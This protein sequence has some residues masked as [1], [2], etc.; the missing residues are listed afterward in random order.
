MKTVKIDIEKLGAIKDSSIELGPLMIFSGES[1]LG[2]S[3][4]SF[5]THYLYILLT[6]D[7]LSGFFNDKEFD[8]DK[9][10][11]G[12]KD[13]G[14]VL[15]I[16]TQE[17]LEWINKDAISYIGYLLGYASFEGR[18][19]IQLP[20]DNASL[21]YKFE[22]EIMGLNNSE[23]VFYKIMLKTFVYR[24]PSTQGH[25]GTGPFVTLL[26]AVLSDSIFSDYR[27]VKRTY[28]MPTS[29]GSLVELNSRPSF[30]S[31]MYEEYF[32]NK[33]ELERPLKESNV[34]I[35][36]DLLECLSEINVGDI[37]RIEGQMIYFTNGVQMPVT[38]AASSIKE[39]APLTM[40]FK[41]YSAKGSSILFEEP[42]A[43]LHPDRQ[44]RVADLVGCAIG[45]GCHMQITT[46]SDYFIRRLNSLISLHKLKEKDKR[47]FDEISHKFGFK[48][49]NIIDPQNVKAYLLR[50]R[51]NG[52]TE[53][54]EQPITN[55]G[56]PFDSF[57]KV[58]E[59]D[60]ISYRTIQ[61]ELK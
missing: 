14:V 37:Q 55:D 24:V 53:I 2:K 61:N 9:L 47:K 33:E 19:N 54:V 23:E 6:T 50:K 49:K 20:T 56:I 36:A 7:R 52:S 11:S 40:F 59:D 15:E 60:I 51:D 32:D 17:L 58:I 43:H 57:Y 16:N 18:V 25:Y 44:A 39:L 10:L 28:L 35:S 5:L 38:A 13:K 48:E 31:G 22:E 30:S 1:G 34:E 26:K 42:E 29:R 41:K 3:Y 8:F 12:K 4:V 45:L 27:F 21:S 46:H